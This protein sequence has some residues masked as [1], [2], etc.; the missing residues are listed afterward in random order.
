MRRAGVAAEG[1]HAAEVAFA[2]FADVGYEQEVVPGGGQARNGFQGFG[3][4]EQ[5]C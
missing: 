4:G 3:D 5:G 1:T 2:F